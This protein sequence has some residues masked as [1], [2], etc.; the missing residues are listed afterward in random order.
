MVSQGSQTYIRI[1]FNRGRWHMSLASPAPFALRMPSAV[2]EG[3]GRVNACGQNFSNFYYNILPQ[4]A[5]SHFF[6]CFHHI[7]MEPRLNCSAIFLFPR[8]L[9]GKAYCFEWA[10]LQTKYSIVLNW[11][12]CVVVWRSDSE[13]KAGEDHPAWKVRTRPTIF[14]R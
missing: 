13:W 5:P 3:T 10:P 4:R 6:F 9:P 11:L 14:K 2:A 12:P 1:V 8:Y 7:H